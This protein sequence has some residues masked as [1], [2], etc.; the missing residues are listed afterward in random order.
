MLEKSLED[1]LRLGWPVQRLIQLT[2]QKDIKV[3]CL[4]LFYCWWCCYC[5]CYWLLSLLLWL[6]LLFFWCFCSCC[7]ELGSVYIFSFFIGGSA[8]LKSYSR[9]ATRCKCCCKLVS[10]TYTSLIYYYLRNCDNECP[11]IQINIVL[12]IVIF[13]RKLF[14]NFFWIILYFL[15]VLWMLT[16]SQ[17]LQL[18]M[19][20]TKKYKI[21]WKVL[22]KQSEICVMQL[23]FLQNCSL[24][25]MQMLSSFFQIRYYIIK[26]K[27]LNC[28][29]HYYG[30][31]YDAN[32]C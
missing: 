1:L 12:Y 22:T 15:R 31:E 5:C 3:C 32:I 19:Q 26:K 10:C 29:N 17:L 11:I 6:L 4:D 20:L 25:L 13:L 28:G 14:F 27:S 23:I 2:Q 18:I 7:R 16:P 9:M 24:L 30:T 8:C 21:L